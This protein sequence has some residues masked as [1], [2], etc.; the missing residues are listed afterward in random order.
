MDSAQRHCCQRSISSCK[1]GLH[2]VGPVVTTL[3][4]SSVIPLTIWA[5]TWSWPFIGSP[6]VLTTNFLI[7]AAI[8]LVGLLAYNS[9]TLL[10]ARQ[11]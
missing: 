11:S 5:F 2:A 9:P 4:L 7:G 8:M 6:A 10:A 1:T 3:S